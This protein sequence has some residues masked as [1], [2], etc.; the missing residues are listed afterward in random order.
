MVLIVA[1]TATLTLSKPDKPG[2]TY[3]YVMSSVS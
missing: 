1:I 3:S 2:P